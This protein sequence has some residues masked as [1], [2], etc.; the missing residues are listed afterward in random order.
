MS[1]TKQCRDLKLGDSTYIECD[2]VSQSNNITR[3]MGAI[4]RFPAE[5]QETIFLPMVTNKPEGTGLGLPIAQ[6]LVQRHG[7]L[8]EYDIC[9]GKTCFIVYLPLETPYANNK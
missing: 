2:S 4:A 5:M 6:T 7:G 3:R 9:N 8:I 1:V